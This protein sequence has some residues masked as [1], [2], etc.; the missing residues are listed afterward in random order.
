[1]KEQGGFSKARMMVHEAYYTLHDY[2]KQEIAYDRLG[3]KT[4][5]FRKDYDLL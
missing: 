2:R 1:V 5:L 4:Y 3:V